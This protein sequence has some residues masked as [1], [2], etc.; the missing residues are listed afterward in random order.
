VRDNRVLW[1]KYEDRYLISSKTS[2]K[3]S[4]TSD[5]SKEYK[6]TSNYRNSHV[7]SFPISPQHS[8]NQPTQT[9]EVFAWGYFMTLE[10][11][12]FQ[13]IQNEGRLQSFGQEVSCKVKN[14]TEYDLKKPYR[15]EQRFQAYK[16]SRF[17][18]R[19]CPKTNET[20]ANEFA[21]QTPDLHRISESWSNFF[22]GSK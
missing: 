19:F 7:P 10:N 6:L 5:G 2:Q 4:Q 17:K 11:N 12:P 9:K 8:F 21:P 16:F 22:H 15:L 13:M 1:T 14:L 18:K 3:S 20:S